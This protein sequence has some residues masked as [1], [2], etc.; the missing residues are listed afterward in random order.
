[1][2]T[3]LMKNHQGQEIGACAVGLSPQSNAIF[4]S[5]NFLTSEQDY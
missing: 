4:I 2:G 3:A 5:K 1:M